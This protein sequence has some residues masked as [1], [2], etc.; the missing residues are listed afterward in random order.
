MYSLVYGR[1]T[2]IN[3]DPVEKKPLYH[4]LPGSKLLSFGTVGCNFDCAF[5]Q[6]YTTTQV[7]KNASSL[8]WVI[9]RYSQKIT[10]KDLVDLALSQKAA[11]I[12]YT[13]NEPAVFVEFARDTAKIAKRHGLKNV[14]VSNGFE[15][16]E[17]FEYMHGLIDAVN[18]DLKSFR[19]EFYLTVCKARLEPVLENIRSFFTAGIHTEITTL[20]IP[21]END[22]PPELT[23][24]ASFI[25]SVSPDIPWHISAFFPAYRLTDIPPTS[26]SSMLSAYR[27]GQK[28]GLR[29][30]YLGNVRDPQKSATY[31]PGC[32][33]TL[34]DRQTYRTSLKNFSP[35]SGTCPRC[36]EE[37]AG[38]W[39]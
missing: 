19:P 30:I 22:S 12:A 26:Y 25:R 16:P 33:Q 7:N 15:S 27:I 35:D 31:C 23:D 9:N 11:G 32:G 10:P 13:Y 36:G 28:A 29:Y 8:D 4:F 5:C 14:Y 2:D 1:P 21:G 24:I 34:I 20:L 38:V 17:A 18:V 37:I 39:H 6:N 3:L